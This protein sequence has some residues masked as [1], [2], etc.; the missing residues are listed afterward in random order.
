MKKLL[1]ILVPLWLLLSCD[2]SEELKVDSQ[3]LYLAETGGSGNDNLNC[4]FYFFKTGDYDPTTFKE[5]TDISNVWTSGQIRT[6]S[7]ETV[8]SFF[9]DIVLKAD[10][11]YGI[12]NCAPGK[13]YVVAQVNG[14]KGYLWMANNVTVS[15]YKATT[16]NLLFDDLYKTGYVEWKENN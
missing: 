12:Y 11:K 7:G 6:K 4:S 10:N 9:I 15:E 13:Y 2:K 14:E 8:K 16:I 3:I 1:L 5:V